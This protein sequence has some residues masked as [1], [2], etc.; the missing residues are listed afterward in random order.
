MARQI[1]LE[2]WDGIGLLENP[3]FGLGWEITTRLSRVAFAERLRRDVAQLSQQRRELALRRRLGAVHQ[4]ERQHHQ[5]ACS[6][7]LRGRRS[8]LG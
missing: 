4:V 3:S 6:G 5:L 1:R 2:P 8:D 7:N